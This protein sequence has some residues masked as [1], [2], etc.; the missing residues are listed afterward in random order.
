MLRKILVTTLILCLW[1]T[2]LGANDVILHAGDK[3]PYFGVLV[4]EQRY[5]T[6]RIYENESKALNEMLLEQ[7]FE[8]NRMQQELDFKD[9]GTIRL[10]WFVIGFSAPFLV[11]ILL[12]DRCNAFGS[13]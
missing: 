13:K 10:R 12:K 7:N 3:A 5:R 11:C 1:K 6:F 2:S 8:M 9:Y 4:S